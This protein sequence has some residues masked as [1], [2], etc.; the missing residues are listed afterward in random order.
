MGLWENI[1]AISKYHHSKDSNLVMPEC[2][3][4]WVYWDTT[5]LHIAVTRFI[6]T[7]IQASIRLMMYHKH[8]GSLPYLINTCWRCVIHLLLIP[9]ALFMALHFS[10]LPMA[11]IVSKI[12]THSV[13]DAVLV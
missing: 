6:K 8:Q 12:I 13:F 3:I 4:V 1:I 5:S 10:R 2:Q 9:K 7:Q 11:G